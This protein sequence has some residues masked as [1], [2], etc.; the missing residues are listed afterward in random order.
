MPCARTTSTTGVSDDA[1]QTAYPDRPHHA[2]FFDRER[3]PAMLQRKRRLAEQFA[4]PA[5][6]GGDV[7]GIVGCDLFEVVDGRNHLAGAQRRGARTSM[8]SSTFNSSTI[9]A[10]FELP[11]GFS[12]FGNVADRGDAALHGGDDIAAPF[13]T[14]KALRQRA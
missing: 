7:G 3:Q 13:G 5:V 12:I 1:S 8:R 2:A 11:R 14:V 10:P 4:P 6:Q 9:A